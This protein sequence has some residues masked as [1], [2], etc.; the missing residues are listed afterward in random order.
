MQRGHKEGLL[1]KMVVFRRKK[2]VK[3]RGSVTHG[4][5]SRKKRRGAGSRGGRGRAGSGK[6]AGHKR[7][8]IVLG[9]SGF[10]PRRDVRG[11]CTV[12]IGYFTVSRVERLLSEGLAR[13]EGSVIVIDLENLG[14]QKLL[15]TGSVLA[16]LKIHAT[17]CS[18]KAKEKIEAAGGQVI[19]AE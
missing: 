17:S 13:K 12:N 14:Y 1:N 10:L 3:Y 11:V 2:V 9:S 18:A 6:R 4:G 8:G 16:K 19:L 15:S 7:Q 5:G